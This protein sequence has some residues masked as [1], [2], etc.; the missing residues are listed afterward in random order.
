MELIFYPN[1]ETGGVC[2]VCPCD[3]ELTTE[4]LAQAVIPAGLPHRVVDKNS[5]TANTN[6]T[7]AWELDFSDPSSSVEVNMSKAKEIHK[8]KIR[9]ARI[10]KFQELDIQFMRCLE[11]GGDTSYIER[12]KAILRDATNTTE[13]SSAVSAE[14]LMESWDFM[15]LGPSPYV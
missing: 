4:E 12:K 3:Q 10:P 8:N 14:E 1:T 6:F 7:D 15:L 9:I 11:V 5:L 13:I 2:I